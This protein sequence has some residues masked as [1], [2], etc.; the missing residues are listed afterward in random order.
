[1]SSPAVARAGGGEA[2][3]SSAAC[4]SS[5]TACTAGKRPVRFTTRG[6]IGATESW[7]YPHAAISSPHPPSNS[8]DTVSPSS[9][10]LSMTIHPIY[11]D[12]ML[13]KVQSIRVSAVSLGKVAVAFRHGK[14][15]APWCVCY[16]TSSK[17]QRAKLHTSS[18]VKH[19][20]APYILLR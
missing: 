2:T 20:I 16:W 10:C 3:A 9:Y 6:L 13:A 11:N 5:D 14:Y 1:M 8:A 18:A 4:R 17:Q 12:P 15:S 19:R 7:T